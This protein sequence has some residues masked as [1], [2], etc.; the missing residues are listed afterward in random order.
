MQLCISNANLQD[1]VTEKERNPVRASVS[2]SC[3]RE[4]RMVRP[5][6]TVCLCAVPDPASDTGWKIEIGP[7]PGWAVVPEWQP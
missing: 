1:A 5:R 7:F 2:F 4:V 6:R 3:A